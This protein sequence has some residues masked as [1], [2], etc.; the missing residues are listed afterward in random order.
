MTRSQ[1]AAISGTASSS[2]IIRNNSTWIKWDEAMFD[3]DLTTPSQFKDYNV[4]FTANNGATTSGQAGWSNFNI[5]SGVHKQ[6]MQFSLAK[7]VSP[8]SEMLE[9][10]QY[11]F[12]LISTT[13]RS[14]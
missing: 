11:L 1:K 6:C 2:I 7:R 14:K 4:T 13:T 9:G 10:I 8:A 3:A 12:V 5:A